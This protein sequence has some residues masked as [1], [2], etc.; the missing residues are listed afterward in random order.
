MFQIIEGW[1]ACALASLR[2][3][4]SMSEVDIVLHA[5]LRAWNMRRDNGN[6]TTIEVQEPVFIPHWIVAGGISRAHV[7]TD[8]SFEAQPCS[9]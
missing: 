4:R 1:R 3:S 2:V 8:S 6:K 7:P 9:D 5:N